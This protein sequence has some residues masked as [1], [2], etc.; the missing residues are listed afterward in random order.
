LTFVTL[1]LV[2]AEMQAPTGISRTVDVARPCRAAR[3]SP[4]SGFACGASN[5]TGLAAQVTQAISE[6]SCKSADLPSQ[7]PE[8]ARQPGYPLPEKSTAMDA[9]QANLQ[10]HRLRMTLLSVVNSLIQSVVI[11]LYA[12]AG[13]IAWPFAAA[14]GAASLGSTGLFAIGVWAGW[15][16]KLGDA[17]LLNAQLAVNFVI[18]IIFLVAIPPLWMIFLASTLITCTYAMV[19]FTPSQFTWLW[20]GYGAVTGMALFAGLGRFET[21]APT[22]ANVAILW[23]FFFMGVRRLALTGAQFS[24]LREQLSEKNKQL[25]ILLE[26]NKE[27]ATHDDLTGT[28]NRRHLMQ[29]LVEERDR[30]DRANEPFS[31]AMLDL[32]HF[33]T[34]NDRFG[35]AGGD[36]V[37]KRFCG[38]SCASIRTTDRFARY[39]GEEFV[40]LMPM[41]TSIDTALQCAE[42]LRCVIAGEDWSATLGAGHTPVTVSAGVATWRQGETVEDL[43]ARAD[44]SLYEAKRQGRNRCV[45]AGAPV[46]VGEPAALVQ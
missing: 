15:L 43:L 35:H 1:T 22:L 7:A 34:I 36:A 10:R 9:R 3:R 33:K 12:A 5:V 13:T 40:L 4:S 39:G 17:R 32:D 31:I 6:E 23:L 46:C 44:A 11:G 20:L 8:S 21:P 16:L 27:L 14:F 30:A 26:R 29:L 18:Q 2:W 37:L 45:A 38:L 28:F 25:T 24:R 41:T 19:A 42:R